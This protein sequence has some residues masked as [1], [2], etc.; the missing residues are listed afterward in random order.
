MTRCERFDKCDW[1]PVKNVGSQTIPSFG[2]MRIT[3][4]EVIE[5][6]PTITV[7]RPDGTLQR[8][9]LINDF[10]SIKADGF[11]RGTFDAYFCLVETGT[12]AFGEGWGVQKDSFKLKAGHP[13]FTSFGGY[14]TEGDVNR[15]IFQSHTINNIQGKLDGS[16]SAGGSATC[17]VWS[18]S[19]DTNI[20]VTVNDFVMSG[21]SIAS[22]RKVYAAFTGPYWV[23]T[24]S[25][26]C[27]EAD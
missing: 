3:G 11:G 14:T 19:A 20:N 27:G 26:N 15:A 25:G 5:G 9:Y 8:H 21:E 17:S 4:T 10:C 7:D 1:I 24:T 12:P 23:V 16:L 6:R 13:G 22:G 18:S 2:V